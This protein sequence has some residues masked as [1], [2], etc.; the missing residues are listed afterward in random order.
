MDNKAGDV[1]A[2]MARNRIEGSLKRLNHGWTL[3]Q[4]IHW[5]RT[6]AVAE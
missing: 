4:Y 5:C 6:L 2:R 1:G 3:P